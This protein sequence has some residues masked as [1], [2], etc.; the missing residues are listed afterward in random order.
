MD[1]GARLQFNLASSVA[2]KNRES[3]P[4]NEQEF[5]AGMV[6]VIGMPVLGIED[7]I[8]DA[9]L[10]IREATRGDGVASLR[11]CAERAEP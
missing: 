2:K 10:G 7:E 11:Y 6:M 1:I 5:V 8:T 9:G 3:P 4:Q